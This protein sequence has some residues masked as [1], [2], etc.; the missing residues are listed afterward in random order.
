MRSIC[1]LPL[2][3]DAITPLNQETRPSRGGHTSGGMNVLGA[4]LRVTQYPEPEPPV[5][6][7]LCGQLEPRYTV[8]AG[9][10]EDDAGQLP[11]VTGISELLDDLE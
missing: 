8:L 9:V 2:T 4:Q 5:E 3:Q 7:L 11:V 6:Y 1:V 10:R